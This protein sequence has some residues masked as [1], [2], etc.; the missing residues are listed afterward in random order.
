MTERNRSVVNSKDGRIVLTAI[1]CLATN[2]YQ[3][4]RTSIQQLASLT[5]LSTRE[6]TIALIRLRED[7]A[8]ICSLPTRAAERFP[9]RLDFPIPTVQKAEVF[10]HRADEPVCVPDRP[11]VSVDSSGLAW[12]LAS[13]LDDLE[14]LEQYQGCVDNYPG[15]NIRSAWQKTAAV[16]RDRIYKA[17]FNLF[18]WFLNHQD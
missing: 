2:E 9:I 8:I 11:E 16:P 13:E 17:P 1:R 14:H 10:S 12:Q 7:A 4:T 5:R 3:P 18:R 6:V 15:S